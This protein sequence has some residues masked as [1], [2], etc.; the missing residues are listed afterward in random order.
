VTEFGPWDK[1][2]KVAPYH[3]RD[4]QFSF[5]PDG[6]AYLTGSGTDPAYTGR[7]M[8]FRSKDMKQWE[9]VD[10]Q[11]D[12]LKQ[13]PGATPEDYEARFGK[14]KKKR[15]LEGQYMD[16]EIYNLAGTFH[17][18]TSLYGTKSGSR[19]PAGGSMWLRSTTGKPEGPYAYVDRARAQSSVFVEGDKTYLFYNGNLLPFDPKGNKL[20]GEPMRLRT[21]MGTSFSKG[22]V[23]TNLLK[24]HGKY[25]VFAT[26][27]CGGTYGEN[28]RIDGTY[29]WVYW[30]SDK[31]EGP[32]EMPRRAY[33]MPHCGHS[34][35][36]LQGKDGR[37]YGL[38]F[39]NDS[40][41]P[42]PNYPGVLVFD[43]RLDPDD[44]V[45]IEL[46]DELP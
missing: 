44:T 26:G 9:P 38:F 20:Q 11:F 4:L 22:D 35:P 6:Y 24:I 34:C 5:A 19:E 30:Q 46:Q 27:W 1:V 41:G 16:S 45:R 28:Y 14:T 12:Y 15:G 42:W 7:I 33:A 8:V 29:D 43:V 21:T 17:I 13:V 18:F 32:Y 40:T 36:P 3:I 39:G 2:P 25:V 37:W 10:V 31:L 23:A